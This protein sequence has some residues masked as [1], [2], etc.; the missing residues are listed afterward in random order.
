MADK[1][2]I[3]IAVPG[4]PQLTVGEG[5]DAS[6]PFVIPEEDPCS[7]GKPLGDA[8]VF[9]APIGNGKVMFGG[10]QCTCG[11]KSWRAS[12]TGKEISEL[13]WRVGAAAELN[14]FYGDENGFYRD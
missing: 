10:Y 13:E 7:C 2:K 8:P 14:G 5:V 1:L 9:T 3:K 12:S 4:F 6:K 11:R